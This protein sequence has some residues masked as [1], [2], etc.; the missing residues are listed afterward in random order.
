MRE[1]FIN[2]MLGGSHMYK[3]P[4][5]DLNY[6]EE[7][8][9]A[10]IDVF[11][12]KWISMG[13]KCKELESLFES[14]I[15]VKHAL[16]VANC[17]DALHLAC[18]STGIQKNDEV[19]CPSLTFAATVNAIRYVGGVPVFCD[20]VSEN[21]LT[22]DPEKI[23]ES[24]TSKTK[25]I[26]VMDYAGFPCE[27]DSIMQIARKYSLK[28]IEDCCHGPMSQYRGKCLGSIGDIG[29][30]SFFS[31]KNISTGEGGMITTND[32]CIY[33][34][35]KSLRSHGMT[36]MSYER[37]RG[38]ATEYDIKEIGF[39]FRM[40]DIHASL[41]IAQLGKLKKDLERRKEIRGLYEDY[42]GNIEE[43]T[44]PFY[45]HVGFVSNYIM[46]LVLKNSTK[47][48]RDEMREHLAEKGIQTS[49]HYPAIHRFSAYKQ[50]TKSLPVTEYVADN[51]FTIPMYASLEDE[52]VKYI[53][54]C[55]YS[56]KRAVFGN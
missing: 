11:R 33:D 7:E 46:P 32:D 31:N 53:C 41:A 2:S 8:E 21:N 36:S 6:G 39:N 26:I 14:N 47:K 23:E 37:A 44:I 38:H 56:S 43:I 13:P 19:I 1:F 18:Y 9:Q 12:S 50:F 27:M 40:D 10:V 22:I 20:I 15:G 24:V 29:C 3:I 52:Q 5:F 45:G 4:L 34:R 17:T 51:E 35:C 49:V 30:F 55:I 28:V 25:A 48:K 54:E 16:S 42:L